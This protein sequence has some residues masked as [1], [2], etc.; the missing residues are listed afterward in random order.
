MTEKNSVGEN[1]IRNTLELRFLNYLSTCKNTQK[2]SFN[3]NVATSP[4]IHIW[5]G[6]CGN[7]P[8]VIN[9]PENIDDDIVLNRALLSPKACVDVFAYIWAALVQIMPNKIMLN[10]PCQTLKDTQVF[11]LDINSGSI[12]ADEE[13]I[14][15]FFSDKLDPRGKSD[16][17]MA[18]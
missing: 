5:N 8:V 7:C 2:S 4:Y 1:L 17:I 16:G 13:S 12:T 9:I 14:S 11:N 15:G 6:I 3:P 10:Y 18:R